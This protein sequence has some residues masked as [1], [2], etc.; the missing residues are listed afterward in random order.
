MSPLF[1][2]YTGPSLI[3]RRRHTANFTTI[4]NIL[5]DDDRLA[6]DEVGI[7]AYLLS[8]PRD[9]EVRRP[10]LMRRW[11]IGREAMKRIVFNW[12]RTGWC[13]PVRERAPNGTTFVIYEIRDQPG[14][15]VTDEEV[16]KALSLGSSDAGSDEFTGQSAPSDDVPETNSPP[17]GYPSLADPSPGDPYVA[18]NIIQNT[19]LP[20]T[21]SDQKAERE[22]TRAREKHAL[23]LV[24]F[25]RRWPTTASD[26]QSRLDRA[27]FELSF[28][29]G[30]AALA[31]IAPFLENQKKLGRKHAPA[32]FTYLE[33]K[34]WTLLEQKVDNAAVAVTHPLASREAKA[35]I[36]LYEVAHCTGFLRGVM[37]RNGAVNYSKPISEKLGKM[38]DA[39]SKDDW[40]TLSRQ[41][42]GAWDSFVRE[43]INLPNRRTLR[44]GDRA[45]WAWPPRKDGTLSET[46]PPGTDTLMTEQD[47][48][49]FK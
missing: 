23:N 29:D 13:W 32:G 46:G 47:L 38:A 26:D 43:I 17:T 1:R 39:G 30:E 4:S 25:K 33:Q 11:G 34:R 16:R 27:W 49:E 6:A 42:A 31:G 22:H 15:S 8:R 36:A 5:F 37:I 28:E 12:I 20:K 10:A 7:L 3:I 18:N 48:A 19:D 44:E 45:P 35:I 41:Q 24:E 40:V 9:W 2:L 21:D 14:P